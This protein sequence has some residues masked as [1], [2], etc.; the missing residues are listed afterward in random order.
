DYYFYE[1]EFTGD[2]LKKSKNDEKDSAWKA[3][4]DARKHSK[5]GDAENLWLRRMVERPTNVRWREDEEEKSHGKLR[6]I[7]EFDLPG[8][9]TKHETLSAQKFRIEELNK[10]T[11]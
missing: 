7:V 6:V 4:E 1:D 3:I 8:N 9:R 2:G 5:V 11:E 10:G